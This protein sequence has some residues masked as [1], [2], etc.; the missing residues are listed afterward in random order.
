MMHIETT[1]ADW[2]DEDT[3]RALRQ[4]AEALSREHGNCT[5]E[6][7]NEDNIVL[8]AVTGDWK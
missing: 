7:Y 2:Q 1:D 8:D 4:Q 5:V 3:R 6:I